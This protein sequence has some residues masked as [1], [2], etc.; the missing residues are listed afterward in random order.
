MEKNL[1]MPSAVTR[2]IRVSFVLARLA[3]GLA[4]ATFGFFVPDLGEGNDVEGCLFLGAAFTAV[5][6]DFF[7]G[8]IY[9]ETS[10]S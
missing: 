4:F 7:F 2:P 5:D 3:G 6:F 8:G 10:T 1:A 9:K